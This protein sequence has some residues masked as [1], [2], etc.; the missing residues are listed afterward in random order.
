MPGVSNVG[1][2]RHLGHYESLK[3]ATLADSPHIH[4][5]VT[6]HRKRVSGRQLVLHVRDMMHM[7]TGS[8]RRKF[9]VRLSVAD[10]GQVG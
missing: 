10:E 9:I 4:A 2:R 3:H 5:Q 7:G 6:V 1:D 8:L